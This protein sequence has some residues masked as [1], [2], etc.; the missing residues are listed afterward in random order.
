M[1]KINRSQPG[2]HDP[3]FQSL[4]SIPRNWWILNWKKKKKIKSEIKSPMP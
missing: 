1:K 4:E 3:G 2:Q